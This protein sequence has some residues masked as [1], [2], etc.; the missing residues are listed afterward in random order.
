MFTHHIYKAKATVA[1]ALYIWWVTY[2]LQV[3][4]VLLATVCTPLHTYPSPA[5][6]AVPGMVWSS[7]LTFLCSEPASKTTNKVTVPSLSTT[8]YSS[9]WNPM[10][11]SMYV[12]QEG[13][14][15]YVCAC[16]CVCVCVCVGR[17]GK[18]RGWIT[19]SIKKYHTR[20]FDKKIQNCNFHR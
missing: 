10:V 4:P 1:F 9:G 20:F 2:Y 13:K 16:V 12:G 17:G 3:A 8:V 18:W 5:I 11:T 15:V 14:D 7:T 19:H 6:I